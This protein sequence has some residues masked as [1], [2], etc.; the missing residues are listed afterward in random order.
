MSIPVMAGIAMIAL[1]LGGNGIALAHWLFWR[2]SPR[3]FWLSSALI[4]VGV[5]V[6]VLSGGA[7]NIERTSIVFEPAKRDQLDRLA[8]CQLPRMLG[9]MLIFAPIVVLL[10]PVLLYKTYKSGRYWMAVL[11]AGTIGV[12]FQLVY[13]SPIPEAVA[14]RA[15]S[16]EVLKVPD[17]CR[18]SRP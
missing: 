17:N 13:L 1:F 8:T 5:A 14:A 12:V 10:G 2:R 6:L 18:P 16:D 7:E 9:S 4:V 11:V 3:L 15:F